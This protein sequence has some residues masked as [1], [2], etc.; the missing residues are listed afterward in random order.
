MEFSSK[1]I[2]SFGFRKSVTKWFES[3]FSNRKFLVYIDNV[4]SAAGTI[5]CG[6]SR[7]SIL[8]PLLFLLYVNALPQS[9]SEVGFYLY[10]DDTCIFYQHEDVKKFKNVLNKEFLSLCQW[11]I[12]NK[13]SIHFGDEKTR[14]T[15]PSKTSGLREINV[16]FPAHS[17]RQHEK[18]E[19]LDCKLASKFWFQKS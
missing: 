5:N 15:L 18:V 6:V 16:S 7:G 13:M 17:I 19:Y 4:F 14:S 9:L 3:Y 1:K 12:D 2:K 11:F 10:A 8:E